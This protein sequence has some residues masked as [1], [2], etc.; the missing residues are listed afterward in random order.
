M[1]W[2]GH[3]D[4]VVASCAVALY[5]QW[6]L[7]FPTGPQLDGRLRVTTTEIV[8]DC[9]DDEE[10]LAFSLGILFTPLWRTA[11]LIGSR[12]GVVEIRRVSD[13]KAFYLLL[14]TDVGEARRIHAAV[15]QVWHAYHHRWASRP[16]LGRPA[17]STPAEVHAQLGRYFEAARTG[18][19]L[20]PPVLAGD[21]YRWGVSG[22]PVHIRVAPTSESLVVEVVAVV[23]HGVR[24]DRATPAALAELAAV[25]EESCAL[26]RL[27]PAGGGCDLVA[28]SVIT[29]HP[30]LLTDLD[31]AVRA[32]VARA[33]AALPLVAALNGVP[34][35]SA[36]APPLPARPDPTDHP[37]RGNEES[38]FLRVLSTVETMGMPVT[39][40]R[41]S[42][43]EARFSVS[44]FAVSLRRGPV[45]VVT[46]RMILGETSPAALTPASVWELI[47]PRTGPFRIACLTH[48]ASGTVWLTRSADVVVCEQGGNNIATTLELLAAPDAAIDALRVRFGCR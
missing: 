9:G 28:T 35:S 33:R 38:T 20:A 24:L 5:G 23:G 29:A 13:H 44:A 42:A 34:A 7:G 21:S 15:T 47:G 43:T 3:P 19:G 12:M 31:E 10:E 26:L 2:T 36:A 39:D 41:W 4:T 25:P 22:F 18:M 45:P 17:P 37:L 8:V 40:Y 27:V 16:P 11:T 14:M 46:L 30:L 32:T 48:A 6:G 1:T